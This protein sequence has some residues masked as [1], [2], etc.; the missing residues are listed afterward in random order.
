[1]RQISNK[2]YLKYLE[3][4]KATI[5]GRILTPGGLKLI[6]QSYNNDPTEIGKHFLQTLHRIEHESAFS[7]NSIF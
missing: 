2:E 1:M 3:Y 5:S 7:E 6:C 4:K